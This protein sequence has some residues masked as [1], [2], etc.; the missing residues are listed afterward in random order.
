MYRETAQRSYEDEMMRRTE[1][2]AETG[3]DGEEGLEARI[4]SDIVNLLTEADAV[5]EVAART[6]LVTARC[7]A[8]T[9]C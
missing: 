4:Y 1:G 3:E 2:D 5:G 8:D 6:R 9:A 7:T